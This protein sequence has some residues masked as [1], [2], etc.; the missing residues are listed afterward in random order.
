MIKHCW[1]QAAA[2]FVIA[3]GI[4][5]G[6]F[7]YMAQNTGPKKVNQPSK[8]LC[9]NHDVLSCMTRYLG[10]MG[11]LKETG[12]DEYEPTNFAKSLSLPIIAGGYTCM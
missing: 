10:S 4:E 11:Y 9:F 5:S 7:K 2:S 8:A 1:A 12:T 6:L 3:T